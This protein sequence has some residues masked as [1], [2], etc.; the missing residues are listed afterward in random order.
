VQFPYGS[1]YTMVLTDG[2]GFGSGKL[3]NYALGC[4]THRTVK[5]SG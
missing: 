2:T 3:P 4:A 5:L 1:Y